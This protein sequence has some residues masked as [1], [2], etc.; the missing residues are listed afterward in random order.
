LILRNTLLLAAAEAFIGTGQQMV[1]VLGSIIVVRLLGSAV[2]AG[3][4]SSILGLTRVL[5]SYPSGQI[6]DARGRKPIL[7]LGLLLALVGAVGLGLAVLWASFPFFVLS[8]IV[9][10]IGN[11][12][13]QQQRRLA[14]TDLYPPERRAQGLGIVLTGAVIGAF[15]GPLLIRLAGSW[16]HTW[17]IDVLALSWFLVPIVLIPSLG[18]LILIRPDPR[19]IAMS[20]ERFYPGYKPSRAAVPVQAIGKLRF[21]SF[22]RTYPHLVAF[23]CMFVLFGNM[24]MMMALT[25]LAMADQG[26]GL[27]AISLTVSVHVFGMFGL[28]I[29]LGRLADQ[30][31]RRPVLF[32]GVS[33]STVGTILVALTSSY[34]LIMLGLFLVGVGWSAGNVA[35]AALVAD[36]SSPAVRGRAMGANSSLSAIASVVAPLLGGLLL[37]SFGPGALVVLT[38]LFVA[39]CVVLLM[40]L[41][42]PS[43]GVY[44]HRTLLDVSA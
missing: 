28:S 6:A 38:L 2:F 40:R 25:P 23:V 8:V 43:P 9:F 10:G 7:I 37:Q 22:L 42:E 31:G 5:V 26:M 3:L 30:L 33:L 36:T 15:G 11:G 41:R 4:A 14:A 17:N 32:A 24:A 21:T 29:P 27:S 35:T 16:A 13:S 39:P 18:L 44:A 34:P 19:D 12:T 1:P 20:L